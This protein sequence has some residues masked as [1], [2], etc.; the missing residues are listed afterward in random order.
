MDKT[1]V[2]FKWNPKHDQTEFIRQVD[3]QQKGLNNLTLEEYLTNRTNYRSSGRSAEGTKAQ[4]L[5]REDALKDR[6]IESRKKGLKKEAAEDEAKKWMKTQAALHNPDQIAGGDPTDITG[7]GDKRVNSSLGSQWRNKH[8]EF[9][10]N[11]DAAISAELAQFNLSD[12]QL[13]DILN[14]NFTNC[15][16]DVLDHLKTAKPNIELRTTNISAPTAVSAEEN[17]PVQSIE[18]TS[19]KEPRAPPAKPNEPFHAA[20]APPIEIYKVSACRC[21]ILRP[22]G[23]IQ[24]SAGKSIATISWKTKDYIP[25]IDFYEEG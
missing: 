23:M 19:T 17:A 13:A 11:M 10:N 1:I 14:G 22:G 24:N 9:H 6:I 2:N 18:P 8:V 7:V 20:F 25:V 3:M 12:Q 4:K 21:N 15:P 16:Q 5:A